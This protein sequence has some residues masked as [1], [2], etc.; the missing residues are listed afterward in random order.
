MVAVVRGV[1][2]GLVLLV[3]LVAGML[4]ATRLDFEIGAY[5]AIGVLFLAAIA[6]LFGFLPGVGDWSDCGGGD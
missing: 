1:A 3:L 6:K 2:F 4:S 5:V